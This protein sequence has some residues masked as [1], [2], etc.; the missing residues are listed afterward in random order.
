MFVLLLT[1][2]VSVADAFEDDAV[3]DGVGAGVDIGDD[4]D[5][6]GDVVGVY[7]VFD[8]V[9]FETAKM[10]LDDDNAAAVDTA[11]VE[12]DDV[13]F[14]LEELAAATAPSSFPL[15]IPLITAAAKMI[16]NTGI[17]MSA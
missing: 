13:A 1:E 4:D 14:A 2:A 5:D 15:K 3:G 8:V 7:D 6:G 11:A 9:A 10:D 16:R 17:Q 12:F